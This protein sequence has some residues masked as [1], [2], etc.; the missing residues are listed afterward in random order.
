[1]LKI[2]RY[3][4][5]SLRAPARPVVAPWDSDLIPEKILIESLREL[6]AVGIAANQVGDPRA[7]CVVGI[8]ERVPFIMVNPEIV[9][10]AEQTGFEDEGCLSLPGITVAVHRPLWV[11]VVWQTMEGEEAAERFGGLAARIVC[12]ELEHLRGGL[13]LDHLSLL[14]RRK[15]QSY[16]AR[17]V[18]IERRNLK[19]VLQGV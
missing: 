14:K 13:I 4:D 10:Q 11:R 1:M 12:H 19:M 15:L 9:E 17:C 16:I 8:P 7:F 2:L 18:R 3:P 6:N 5:R